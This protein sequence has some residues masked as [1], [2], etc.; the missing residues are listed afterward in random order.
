[1]SHN[2]MSCDFLIAILPWLPGN[3]LPKWAQMEYSSATMN[4]SSRIPS[5]IRQRF[6]T[7]FPNFDAIIGPGKCG[8]LC[9]SK[10]MS[11]GE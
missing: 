6:K 1:M 7:P 3:T 4:T 9:Q 8:P 2:V 10:H 11:F 5:Q